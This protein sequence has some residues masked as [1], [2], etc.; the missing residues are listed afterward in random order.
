MAATPL[1]VYH[2]AQHCCWVCKQPIQTP[3]YLHSS[4]YHIF[5]HHTDY[6]TY[7]QGWSFSSN[8]FYARICNACNAQEVL[9]YQECVQAKSR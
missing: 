2:N 5:D 8:D 1:D 6:Q 7:Y 4:P 9:I 3:I